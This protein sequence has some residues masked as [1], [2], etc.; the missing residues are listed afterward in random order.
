MSRFSFTRMH[1]LLWR[2]HTG[3]CDAKALNTTNHTNNNLGGNAMKRLQ[4]FAVMLPLVVMLAGACLWLGGCANTSPVLTTPDNPVSVADFFP[5]ALLAEPI[6]MRAGYTHTTQAFQVSDPDPVWEVSM[7][8]VRRDDQMS[9]KRFACLVDSRK[10]QLRDIRSCS[11]DEPG[12]YMKWELLR[13]DGV[14]IPGFTYDALK[15]QT[16]SQW[17]S[18]VR[19]GLG[20]FTNQAAGSYRVKVTVLRDFPELDVTS[21]RI[22]IDKPFFRRN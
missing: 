5:N 6:K 12:I 7:G 18:A 2:V 19:V 13:S 16:N 1:M 15:E 20:A 9:F 21:P 22:V 3:A 14:V 11:N 10:S 17:G 4:K 8:F